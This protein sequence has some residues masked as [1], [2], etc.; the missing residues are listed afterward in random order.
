MTFALATG[1]GKTRLMAALMAYLYLSGQSQTYLLLA[2]RTAILRKIL[3]DLRSS[4]RYLFVDQ[5]MIPTPRVWHAGN[6]ES[7]R[8]PD[9]VDELLPR[10][11]DLFVFSP[12]AITGDDRRIG[13]ASEFVGDSP[14]SYLRSAKDL[15]VL[16]DEAHHLRRMAE[17]DTRAWTQ[18]VRDV[19]PRLQLGM[20]AT[21]EDAPGSNVLYSYDLRTALRERLYTKDVRL[22]VRE[23]KEG[24]GLG[25]A[26]WDRITL[27][28]ALDR[29][30]A[31]E[32]AVGAYTGVRP[33][34]SIKPVLLVAAQDTDH[35]EEI[36][37][38]LTEE[39]GLGRQEVLVV[40]SKRSK[41]EEDLQ[42]LV[43]IQ[44]K[45]NKVRVVVNV[46]E[47]TEGWDVTN[48]YVIA[49]LR[50]M[51]TFEGAIQTMGR[52]LR[53]PA[54]TRV[55]DVELDTLE[56]LCFGN[57]SLEQIVGSAT[58][59]YGDAENEDTG[60]DVRDSSDLD[61]T[62]TQLPTKIIDVAESSE[63]KLVIPS[64]RRIPEEPDLD[65]D[66]RAV[67]EIAQQSATE[68]QL[69]TLSV[70]GSKAS[71]GF[72]PDVVTRLVT[73]RILASLRYL[74][75]PLHSESVQQLATRFVETLPTG[76]DGLV[77]TDWATIASILAHEIDRRY[78]R[79]LIKF[80]VIPG[81]TEVAFGSYQ[82]HVPESLDAFPKQ[83]GVNG[84]RRSWRRIPIVG[85]NRCVSD[86]V[87][88]DT[89]PEYRVAVILDRSS[90]VRW[91]ARN[92]PAR[93]VVPTPI[94][95]HNPDFVFQQDGADGALLFEVK[96]ANLWEAPTS[97]AR[98]KAKAAEGWC[99]A[100]SSAAPER[101]R[102]KLILDADVETADT[103]EAL[104]AASV[105]P[106]PTSPG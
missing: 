70:A 41:T 38:W 3:S 50:A 81:G 57:E 48:V 45:D 8:G 67:R 40:H 52:G 59:A 106:L 15:V 101:W 84:W 31:K 25:D 20:T 94:G 4:D 35:A 97:D 37:R 62:D 91:W 2:P 28:F 49:P 9:E 5:E 95:G 63:A 12:Q 29:L 1:V 27:N 75:G 19:G 18:A 26:D 43:G 100:V 32:A 65:F 54:G 87:P 93:L 51:S 73:S 92:D 86:A 79:K 10:G 72:K 16:V 103:V 13:K 82:W 23:K 36:G 90:T 6:V 99:E 44:S 61:D 30:A 89:E 66:V 69:A 105:G 42:R 33:F 7:F 96:Q 98:V 53:L 78:R 77:T 83:D 71:L 11:P 46:F 21:P 64:I 74:S 60:F 47:L 102:Y 88:F 80:E 39:K 22:V 24:D 76:E 56:V 14:L 55:D 17:A 85:W 34:P 104:I 58:A 68:L